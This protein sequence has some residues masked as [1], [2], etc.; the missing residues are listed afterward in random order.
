MKSFIPL[1]IVPLFAASCNSKLAMNEDMQPVVSVGNKT[2]YKNELNENLQTGLS[3]EDSII[4]AEHYIRTW[5]ND[6]LLYDV[7]VKNNNDKQYIDRLVESYRK[8]LLIYQ[9]EEQLINEKLTKEFDSNTLLRFYEE[10]KDKFKLDKPLIKGIFLKIPVNAPQ[11]DE[12]R[13][14]YKSVTPASREKMEKYSVHNAVI[15]DY[16]VTQWVNFNEVLN[17]WPAEYRD[18]VAFLNQNRYIEQ[19]DSS[20]FYFLNITDFLLPGNN[21]PFEYAKPIVQEMLINQRRLEFLKRTE[22]DLYD[23]AIKKG[24]IKFYEE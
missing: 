20:F 14:W 4:E 10:N 11:I 1:L 2:L 22:K 18:E 5:I 8:S 17:N 23:R 16:F 15:Y 3:K 21:A 24:E 6:A 13:V 9:Y 7:A 12:V 19:R